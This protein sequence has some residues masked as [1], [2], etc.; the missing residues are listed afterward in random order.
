GNLAYDW[1]I[2]GKEAADAAFAAAA[3]ITK[4]NMKNQRIIVNAMEPRAINALWDTEAEQWD[5]HTV[6]QGVTAMR[7]QLARQLGVDQEKLRVRTPDVGGGFGMKL[8]NHPEYPVAALAAQRLGKPVKWTADRT[9]SFLSDVQAREL[10]TE[11]EL[12]LDADAK[13]IGIRVQSMSNLGAHYS[14]VGA[15][16]HAM[17]SAGLYGTIY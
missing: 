10:V 5:I 13:I 17:F 9:E 1:E 3:H 2:G 16:I 12:A 14:Q 4:L 8:M 7:R 11:A 6:S 15:A